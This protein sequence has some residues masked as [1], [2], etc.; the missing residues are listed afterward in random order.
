MTHDEKDALDAKRRDRRTSLP[1]FV[2][3]FSAAVLFVIVEW[4]G[5][6]PLKRF[7]C[8]FFIIAIVAGLLTYW[9]VR[10]PTDS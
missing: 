10:D 9:Y 1:F 3:F 6:F 2:F 8:S 4:D 5:Y 7:E